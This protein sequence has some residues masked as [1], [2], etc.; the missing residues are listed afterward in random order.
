MGWMSIGSDPTADGGV[1]L[2][3]DGRIGCDLRWA[4]GWPAGVPRFPRRAV[5]EYG[6]DSETLTVGGVQM[7]TFDART[8]S[9]SPE[10]TDPEAV[11]AIIARW[12]PSG[13]DLS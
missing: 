10:V 8:A 9:S 5:S 11:R 3:R 13:E 4:Q 12:Y 2:A 1:G 7:A 6:K